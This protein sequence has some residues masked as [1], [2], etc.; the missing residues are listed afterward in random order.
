MRQIGEYIY[1]LAPTG[2]WLKAGKV[3]NGIVQWYA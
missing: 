1:K 3:V 2:E